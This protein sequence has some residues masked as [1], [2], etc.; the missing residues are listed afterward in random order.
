[1][2]RDQSILGPFFL[3]AT[4][5]G[6]LLWLSGLFA[7]W[8]DNAFTVRQLYA[9]LASNPRRI[10]RHGINGTRRRADW[11]RDNIAG[12]AGS[13]GL[14]ILLGLTPVVHAFFGVPMEVRHVTLST[15]QVAA[16]TFSLGWAAMGETPFW[17]AIAGL[18]LI[19]ALNVG[20]SFGLA[21]RVAMRAVDIS[22]ADRARVYREIRARLLEHP[23]EF[24]WP[25]SYPRDR[26]RLRPGPHLNWAQEANAAEHRLR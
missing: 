15:G 21:L 5:T 20:V 13:I 3:F 17:L 9:A 23:G 26:F 12:L 2:L 18:A 8:A 25:P 16:A 6:V 22:A 11:W 10:R 14:G 1:M 24:L 7:G 4:Y 19:G